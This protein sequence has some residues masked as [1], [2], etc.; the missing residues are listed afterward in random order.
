MSLVAADEL[1]AVPGA[2]KDLDSHYGADLWRAGELGVRAARGRETASFAGI[3]PPWFK[4]AVMAW[5]RHRLALNGAFSTVR[6]ATLA[7]R[8]FSLFAASRRSRLEHP[9]QLDR[10]LLEAY[11]AWLA[12]QPVADSTKTLSRGFLRSF[13]EENR[14]YHWV[15]A[16]PLDAVI[17]PDEI[18]TRRSSLPRFI[19]EFV[20]AQ[21][22][23]EANLDR[24]MVHHRHLVVVI[25]ETGL[26]A[27]DACALARCTGQN[28]FS[29]RP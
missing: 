4:A 29:V 13:L 17:Y 9:D 20:M 10:P 1:R 26:R 7:F 24:L 16:I 5:A 22:E 28:R 11:L 15:D 19:P 14:R 21:L 18:G 2:L 6:A 3:S 8:R 23:D 12:T 25:T 27:G